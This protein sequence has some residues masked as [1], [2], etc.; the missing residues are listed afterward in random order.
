[1]KYLKKYQEHNEGIKSTLATAGLIGSLLSTTPQ[2][3]KSQDLKSVETT[4]PSDGTIVSKNN[5]TKLSHIRKR[6]EVKD[7]KLSTI[8]DEIELNLNNEDTSKYV[9]LFGKLSAHIEQ[10]YGYKIEARKIEQTV[11][12]DGVGDFTKSLSLFEILGWLGSICLAICGIPQAWQSFKDKHSHGISWAFLLLWSFGELFALAY[13]YDKLDIPL[14]M[15]YATNMLILGVIIYYKAK[16]YSSKEEV[17][18]EGGSIRNPY[19][20]K[21]VTSNRK[22]EFL[23]YIQEPVEIRFDVEAIAHALDRQY[24]HGFT[25]GDKI[26][27]GITKDEIIDCIERAVEEI[28]IALMQDQFNIYQEE[29]DY[30][31]R[32]VRA[33]QPNRFVIRNKK[34]HLNIVC[35]LEPGDNEFTLTVITVMKKPDFKEYKG[36]FVV[37][38][39]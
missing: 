27:A 4:I 32:G 18:Q 39:F 9:E 12:T 14:L 17:L 19:I 29:D 30:P 23:T 22:P 2:A 28:T 25:T 26:E 38:V 7:V 6:M 35:Q 11:S 3:V 8:L 20:D 36:Q 1:M 10:Q 21:R 31:T 15:N 5:I 37:E 16:P 13:V 34:T 33:G 24:R